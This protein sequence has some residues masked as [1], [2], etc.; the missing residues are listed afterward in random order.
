[1]AE[2]LLAVVLGLTVANFVNILWLAYK[3]G[4]HEELLATKPKEGGEE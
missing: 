3:V 4:R 2:W 1:M